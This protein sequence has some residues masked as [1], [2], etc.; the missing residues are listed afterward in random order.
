MPKTPKKTK[1]LHNYKLSTVGLDEDG[2]EA[3][4]VFYAYGVES[5]TAAR[6][7]VRADRYNRKVMR[8]QGIDWKTCELLVV[9]CNK[10]GEVTDRN[11]PKELEYRMVEAE[12]LAKMKAARYTGH[13]SPLVRQ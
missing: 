3:R 10:K 2:Q 5:M 13:H 7:Q 4:L 12:R 1:K 6:A 8:R 9:P 11:H